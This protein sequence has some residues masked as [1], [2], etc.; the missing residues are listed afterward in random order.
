MMSMGHSTDLYN[1]WIAIILFAMQAEVRSARHTRPPYCGSY[2]YGVYV[3][4]RPIWN[5]ML[6]IA[7][8]FYI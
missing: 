4:G 8:M 2:L 5:R 6:C 7:E 1:A 3:E